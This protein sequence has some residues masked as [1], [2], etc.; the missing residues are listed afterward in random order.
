MKAPRIPISGHLLLYQE[1]DTTAHTPV[2]LST[3]TYRATNLRTLDFECGLNK[4]T[5]QVRSVRG[6]GQRAS[7]TPFGRLMSRYLTTI[8]GPHI[9]HPTELHFS[10]VLLVFT[11]R[12]YRLSEVPR[13]VFPRRPIT[14]GFGL[15]QIQNLSHP[16]QSRVVGPLHRLHPC[17]WRK[18]RRK[19]RLNVLLR[20]L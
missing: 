20:Y 3:K 14:G 15:V 18:T 2:V 5:A 8:L 6:R 10:M 19:T 17:K 1:R 11:Y 4:L 16:L 12:Q 13:P 7:R 9:F